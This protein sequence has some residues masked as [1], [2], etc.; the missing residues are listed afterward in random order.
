MQEVTPEPKQ[1]YKGLQ[2]TLTSDKTKV[3]DS[4][5][6]KRAAKKWHP[7]DSYKDKEEHTDLSHICQKPLDDPQVFWD[8]VLWNDESKVELIAR[9]SSCYIW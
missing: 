8:D 2:A 1:T 3:Y 5:M 4:I 7:W 6:R 9:H